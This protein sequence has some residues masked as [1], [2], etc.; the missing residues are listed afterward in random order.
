[1]ERYLGQIRAGLGDAPLTIMQSS[2]G[3]MS[4]ADAGRRP[5]YA[6]ESGPAAGVVAS[7]ALAHAL[8]HENV[9]TFDMAARREGVADRARPRLAKPGVR[10]RRRF[11]LG[12]QPPSPAAAGS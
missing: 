11:S 2:G 10:G 4:A 3:V 5:V 6:L 7:A 8:G 9:I 12:R 1:M